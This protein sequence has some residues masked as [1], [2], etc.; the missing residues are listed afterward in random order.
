MFPEAKAR[1]GIELRRTL[2]QQLITAAAR[3]RA[4]SNVRAARWTLEAL[5]QHPPVALETAGRVVG[6]RL[7]APFRSQR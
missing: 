3:E 6:K 1:L 2:A 7:A 5:R 4:T